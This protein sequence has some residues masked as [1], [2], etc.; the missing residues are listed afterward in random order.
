MCSSFFKFIYGV[1]MSMSPLPR[2]SFLP[3]I[4][5]CNGSLYAR[6]IK[7]GFLG[8]SQLSLYL[9][10]L[11]LETVAYLW[12]EGRQSGFLLGTKSIHPIRF[13]CMRVVGASNGCVTWLPNLGLCSCYQS[14]P[15][16]GVVFI[17]GNIWRRSLPS[18]LAL[19]RYHS[20]MIVETFNTIT[21]PYP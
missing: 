19:E 10:K 1:S 16:E 20:W 4:L 18:L 14:E 21:W 11:F 13:Q 5:R 17:L 8:L 15:L 2:T 9:A 3:F 12:L 7:W 6:H